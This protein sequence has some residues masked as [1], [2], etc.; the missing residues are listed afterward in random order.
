M[1]YDTQSINELFLQRLLLDNTKR[2]ALDTP[3][4]ISQLELLQA[5]SAAKFLAQNL[6]V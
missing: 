6:L 4:I 5:V 1:T 2:A 3:M